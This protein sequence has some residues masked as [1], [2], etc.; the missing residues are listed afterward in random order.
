MEEVEICVSQFPVDQI[1]PSEQKHCNSSES[2][3]TS[4]VGWMLKS[5]RDSGLE[6]EQESMRFF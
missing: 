3:A 1:T 6:T 5:Q 2:N 4:T